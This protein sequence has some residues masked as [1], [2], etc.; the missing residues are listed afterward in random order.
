MMMM[1]ELKVSETGSSILKHTRPRLHTNAALQEL[2][3]NFGFMFSFE[4]RFVLVS[5]VT[6]SSTVRKQFSNQK[7]S[8]FAV[9]NMST[10]FSFNFNFSDPDFDSC[11]NLTRLDHS[12]LSRSSLMQK[13]IPDFPNEGTFLR[14][15]HAGR[16]VKCCKHVKRDKVVFYWK[17]IW[18]SVALNTSSED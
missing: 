10:D 5:L 12:R 6:F 13:F 15:R 9:V 11:V 4:T 18:L 1:L 17:K 3:S 8:N 14:R 16:K 2:R 7:K